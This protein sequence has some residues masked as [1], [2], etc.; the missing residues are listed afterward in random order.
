M[1]ATQTPPVIVQPLA[2][3]AARDCELSQEAQALLA[4]QVKAASFLAQLAREGLWMDSLRLAPHALG[5][6]EALWWGA[7]CLWQFYR[8]APPPEADECLTIVVRWLQNRNETNR[9]AAYAA[10]QR[11]KTTTPAGNLAL[12]VFFENGSMSLPD[13]PNVPVK[14]HY[15][16]CTISSAVTLAIKLS[17][18]DERVARQ[19]DYVRLALEVMAGHWPLPALSQE[20]R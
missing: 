19:S 6:A 18:P 5:R 16:P 8:P 3:D 2:V 20:S 15:L 17:P 1:P 7:L 13:Q 11:A 14:P 12:A 4:P 10:G 9:R